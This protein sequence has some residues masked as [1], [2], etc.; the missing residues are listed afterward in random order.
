MYQSSQCQK[1]ILSTREK[2]C[3]D[4]LLKGM[5]AKEIGLKLGLSFRTIEG[6]IENMKRKLMCRNKIE[7]VIALTKDF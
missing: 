6:Y 4:Y 1:I 5:T 2:Q 3:A 7:L